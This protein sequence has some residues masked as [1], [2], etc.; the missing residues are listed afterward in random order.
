[1][2][3]PHHSGGQLQLTGLGADDDVPARHATAVGVIHD[4]LS[5]RMR[6]TEAATRL[7]GQ[8]AIRPRVAKEEN[9]AAQFLSQAKEALRHLLRAQQQRE[10][11]ERLARE[12]Y[13]AARAEY[14]RA[15]TRAAVLEGKAWVRLLEVPGMSVRTAATLGGVSVATVHRRLKEARDA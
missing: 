8:E 1:M 7:I 9:M 2:N 4:G 15:V 14:H 11:H 13:D 5:T 12:R 3:D 6:G 10:R